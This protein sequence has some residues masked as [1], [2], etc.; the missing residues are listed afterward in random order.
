MKHHAEFKE[1]EY[2]SNF[3]EYVGIF[4]VS[5]AVSQLAVS[6]FFSKI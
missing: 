3:F 5:N 4:V 2:N 1:D 6:F